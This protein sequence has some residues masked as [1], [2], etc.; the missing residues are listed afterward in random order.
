[1]EIVSVSIKGACVMVLFLC[2][3]YVNQ[4]LIKGASDMRWFGG[5]IVYETAF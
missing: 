4:G 1:M 3:Q 2:L 5:H